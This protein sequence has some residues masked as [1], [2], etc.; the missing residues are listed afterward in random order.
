MKLSTKS[1]FAARALL[2]LAVHYNGKPVRI[3][4]IAGR[5]SLSERYLENIFLVLKGAGIL[6]SIKGKDGGFSLAVDPGKLSML[7]IVQAVEGELSIVNC[8]ESDSYCEAELN[9][10]TRGVW[11]KVNNSIKASLSSITLKDLIKKYYLNNN[12]NRLMYYI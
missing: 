9:C 2:D 12:Q 7:Q 10:I 6:N 8:L 5:Q 3:K 4:N 1:R 11:E